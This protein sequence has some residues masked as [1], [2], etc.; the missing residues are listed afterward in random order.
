MKA[1]REHL[2]NYT[3]RKLA[4]SD[5]E[6]AADLLVVEHVG[7]LSGLAHLFDRDRV[8]IGEKR[9]ARP[10]YGRIDH[11]R[12]SGSAVLSDIAVRTISPT[13]MRRRSRASW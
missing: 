11:P 12:S 8:E 13:L 5:S 2:Q 6:I 3:M 1:A 9:L 7:L 10:T 4:V